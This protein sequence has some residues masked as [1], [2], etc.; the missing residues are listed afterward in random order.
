MQTRKRPLVNRHYESELGGWY[1]DV[2]PDIDQHHPGR[3]VNPN[4]T[5]TETMQRQLRSDCLEDLWMDG[6]EELGLGRTR[7]ENF[8]G[9]NG[10]QAC[11]SPNHM[12]TSVW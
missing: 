11:V 8:Q 12:T 6:R 5:I 1:V 2:F 10:M 7:H 3:Y 4:A 9:E